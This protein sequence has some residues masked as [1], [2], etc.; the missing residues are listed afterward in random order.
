MGCNSGWFSYRLASAGVATIGVESDPPMTRTAIYVARRA[1][2]L[3]LGI[4][5]LHI[6]A[7]TVEMLPEA[8]C[9]LLLSVWHHMVRD[10]GLDVADA[11][12]RA[13]WRK[14][15]KLLLFDT[16]ESEC[17]EEFHLPPMVPTPEIWLETHLGKCAK[18]PRCATWA[19]M[20]RSRQT[21]P[22]VPGSWSH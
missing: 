17:V 21:A 2:P 7:N 18:A 22:P 10:Y 5:Y 6:D 8:D 12:L 11:I 14:T 13:L 9:I 4:L 19:V 20:L 1:Q 15:R 16:G 3:P